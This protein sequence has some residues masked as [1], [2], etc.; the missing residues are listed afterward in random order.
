VHNRDICLQLE[1]VLAENVKMFIH[2]SN[3]V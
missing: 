1:L 2:Q 3:M